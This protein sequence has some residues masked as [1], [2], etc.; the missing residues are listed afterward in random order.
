MFADIKLVL[1]DLDG[2][3][4]DSI[5]DLAWCVDEMMGKLGLP[6]P[7]EEGARTWIGNGVQKLVER[8]LTGDMDGVPD[9]ELF[10]KAYAI[11]LELYAE[12]TS[13]RSHVYPGV[14][15]GLA[16]VKAAGLRVSCVTNKAAQF[17]D[18][19]L[20][21]LELFDAFEMIVAGDT[22][23]EK[24]PH[25]MPLLHVAESCGIAPEHCLMVGDSRSDVRA[26]R[27][28]GFRILCVSYGYN[29]GEDIR[30]YHPDLVVD[31]LAELK[32]LLE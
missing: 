31:S 32:P 24:K 6:A 12:N 2:T 10:E 20:R 1:F 19:I 7:G 21:E 26:A 25:P 5:P 16:A 29:H 28:A 3:L 8:A 4:V 9:P 15:E 13:K 22:L 11:F 18:S 27:A 30:S 17:T 23:P 14:L